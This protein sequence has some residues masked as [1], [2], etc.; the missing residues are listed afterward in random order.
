MLHM[1]EK[2][3]ITSK[4]YIVELELEIELLN[5][6]I[7]ILER[8]LGKAVVLLSLLLLFLTRIIN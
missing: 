8:Q 4:G 5:A 3:K 2:S 1:F 7:K 6:K